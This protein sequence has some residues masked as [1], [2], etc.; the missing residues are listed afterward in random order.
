MNETKDSKAG[1]KTCEL[2]KAEQQLANPLLANVHGRPLLLLPQ[3]T[4]SCAIPTPTLLLP[5]SLLSLLDALWCSMII[6]CQ[7]VAMQPPDLRLIFLV[8][9]QIWS[10]QCNQISLNILQLGSQECWF[11]SAVPDMRRWVWEDP[12]SSLVT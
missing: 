4:T 7:L 10:L 5:V 8:Q 3:N 12:Q 11:V 6:F 9:M 1:M 2:R